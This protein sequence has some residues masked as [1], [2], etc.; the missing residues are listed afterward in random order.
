MA[1]EKDPFT[2]LHMAIE[3]SLLDAKMKIVSWNSS[4]D[5]QPDQP[6]DDE[7]PEFQARPAGFSG[8]LGGNSAETDITASYQLLLNTGDQRL[9]YALFPQLWKLLG[10]LH[11]L[12]YGTLDTLEFNNRQFVR[13]VTIDAAT[14]GLSNPEVNRGIEGWTALWNVNI[15]CTFAEADFA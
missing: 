6:T 12:K 9:G 4:R 11:G 8:I 14:M 2:K 1:E 3:K 7:L 15:I 13:D 5:P 10:V